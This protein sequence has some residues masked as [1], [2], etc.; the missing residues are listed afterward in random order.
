M[1][2]VSLYLKYLKKPLIPHFLFPKNPTD[3]YIFEY[4]EYIFNLLTSICKKIIKFGGIF[5][6]IDYAR[7]FKKKDG[8]LSAIKNHKKVSIFHD[9]G[10]CELK[11]QS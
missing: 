3:G 9:L 5:I 7:N 10:N 6:I 4:S 2:K 8:T 11:P 1:K